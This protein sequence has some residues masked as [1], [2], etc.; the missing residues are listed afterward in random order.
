MKETIFTWRVVLAILMALLILEPMYIWGNLTFGPGFGWV[1]W[2][3]PFYGFLSSTII[4]LVLA[5]V[6]RHTE[7]PLTDREM[8]AIMVVDQVLSVALLFQAIP[9]IYFFTKSPYR[10]V[11]GISPPSWWAPPEAIGIVEA[12]RRTLLAAEWAKPILLIIFVSFISAFMEIAL[13]YLFFQIRVIEEKLTFPV[14]AAV[15]EVLKTLGGERGKAQQRLFLFSL[16]AGIILGMFNS[17]G[18]LSLSYFDLNLFIERT[19]PGAALAIHPIGFFTGLILPLEVVLVMFLSAFAVYFIGNHFLVVYG[20]WRQVPPSPGLILRGWL[21]GMSCQEI[22]YYSVLN[23]WVSI[24]FGYA[25]ALGILSIAVSPRKVL[26][27]LKIE[28]NGKKVGLELISL[29]TGCAILIA[30]V[31]SYFTGYPLLPLLFLTAVMSFI[32]SYV[33]TGLVGIT[34]YAPY[35]VPYLKEAVL[36]LGAGGRTP[37]SIWFAS[38]L[39]LTDLIPVSNAAIWT[40]RFMQCHYLG[41]KFREYVALFVGVTAIAVAISIVTY[42]LYWS[43][44]P[45]P[46]MLYPGV[47]VWESDVIDKATY[48]K[49]YSSKQIFK[50]TLVLAGFITGVAFFLAGLLLKAPWIAFSILAGLTVD[51]ATY[52]SLLPAL[53]GAVVRQFILPRAVKSEGGG[54]SIMASAYVISGGVTMGFS[55]WAVVLIAIQFISKALW[56]LP[57]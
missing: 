16:L 1:T 45:I 7:N 4:I 3:I 15:V 19:V 38:P 27:A 23:F 26:R 21:E 40:G 20:I 8:L 28:V 34:G 25:M 54:S 55:V 39:M 11:F 48:I 43:F 31:V 24:I 2:G 22:L 10:L 47:S 6:F 57:Y 53:V 46:S 30:L 37:T 49:L 18:L 32:L 12:G 33:M 29:F 51:H 17:I 13:G 44:A 36:V 5:E 42:S 14:Q 52:A 41:V 9:W 50:P 56:V 35:S